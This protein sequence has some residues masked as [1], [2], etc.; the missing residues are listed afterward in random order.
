MRNF[1]SSWPRLATTAVVTAQAL[2]L[3]GYALGIAVIGLTSGL[4]GPEAV[5]SPMGATVEVITFALFGAGLAAIAVGRW[6]TSSWSG[7]PFVLAQLLALT[8]GVPLA[9]AS[10]SVGTTI[11]VLLTASAV[12]GIVGIVASALK[13]PAAIDLREDPPRADP[14]EE[15]QPKPQHAT[16]S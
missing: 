2:A 8:V 1:A 16:E 10:G 4:E 13:T 3:I 11:G 9:T 5:S 12:V 14:P 15:E 6:R 7:P